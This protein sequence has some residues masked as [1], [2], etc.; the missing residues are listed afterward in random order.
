MFQ[1]VDEKRKSPAVGSTV[2]PVEYGSVLSRNNKGDKTHVKAS[3]GAPVI[4]VVCNL[5]E[6]PSEKKHNNL[7]D[8]VWAPRWP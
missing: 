3:C 4:H 7:T 8:G 2:G 1:E 5:R 6:Q